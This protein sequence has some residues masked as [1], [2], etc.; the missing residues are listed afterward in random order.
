M[1]RKRWSEEQIV[2][3]VKQSEAGRTAS[4]DLREGQLS[5]F[6]N[7]SSDR[8]GIVPGHPQI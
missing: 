2:Y 5:V 8:A 6:P 1:P 4:D 3:A 7:K